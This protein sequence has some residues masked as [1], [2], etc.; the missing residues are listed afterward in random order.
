MSESKTINGKDFLKGQ[1]IFDEDTEEIISDGPSVAN[2]FGDQ[3]EGIDLSASSIIVSKLQNSKYAN[4]VWQSYDLGAWSNGRPDPENRDEV[5]FSITSNRNSKIDYAIQKDTSIPVF[6]ESINFTSSDKA[7]TLAARKWEELVPGSNIALDDG[8]YWHRLL[9]VIEQHQVTYRDTSVRKVP[10]TVSYQYSSTID[11]V[12]YGFTDGQ[13][14]ILKVDDINYQQVVDLENHFEL[15]FERDGNDSFLIT[16]GLE[17][18]NERDGSFNYALNSG[19]YALTLNYKFT[20]LDIEGSFITNGNDLYVESEIETITDLKYRFKDANGWSISIDGSVESTIY[21]VGDTDNEY[22]SSDWT[23]SK[24]EINSL[25][26]YQIKNIGNFEIKQNSEDDGNDESSWGNLG[27]AYEENL[28]EVKDGFMR[29]NSSSTRQLYDADNEIRI[30]S[31]GPQT[32]NSERSGVVNA[33]D[34]NDIVHGGAGNDII[35]GG[36]GSDIIYGNAG[37]DTIYGG[38]GENNKLYGGAGN[39]TYY[40]SDSNDEIVDS[41]GR[42]IVYYSGADVYELSDGS[43]VEN[44]T[45]ISN[46]D[47]DQPLGIIGN[48]LNNIL[49]SNQELA[50]EYFNGKAGNDIIN[51]GDGDDILIGGLGNDILTGGDGDDAFVFDSA[52]T[53]N[54]DRIM[55]FDASE[56]DDIVLTTDIFKALDGIEWSDE[57]FKI[58]TKAGDRDDFIIYNPRNGALLYDAD[59]SG[60]GKAVQFAT[61]V[62]KPTA[63]DISYADFVILEPGEIDSFYLNEPES[64][65]L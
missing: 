17:V 3:R 54:V 16:E 35:Y 42:D 44:G 43:N 55:D 65:Y 12:D 26:N 5:K 6:S 64:Y 21:Y 60:K 58:G 13:P 53:R 20:A 46:E 15:S 47:G 10:V 37:N 62:N 34:G 38:Y 52:L 39:D 9:T 29:G 45:L 18:N 1:F 41:A 24:L 51:G 7:I 14:Y 22:V 27:I 57:H 19:Q 61:L 30:L 2:F 33:G 25:K 23:I 63:D 40:V 28:S 48:R 4:E 31:R 49:S 50:D 56:G 36:D 59:G 32:I 11:E 8:T